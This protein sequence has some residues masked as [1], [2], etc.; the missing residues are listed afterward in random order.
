MGGAPHYADK[1]GIPAILAILFPHLVPT[2]G[3]PTLGFPAGRPGSRYNRMT[4]GVVHALAGKIGGGF[5]KNWRSTHG[6]PRPPR[7]TGL[8]KRC[9]GKPIPVLHGFSPEVVPEPEDW[10]PCVHTTGSWFLDRPDDW[11]PPPELVRFLATGDPPVYFGFGSMAGR[12]P[13][14]VTRIV[15]S[16][17]QQTG[18]RGL[19]ATGWGGLARQDLPPTVQLLDQAPHDWLFPCVAAV[20]HHGGAGTTAAGLRAGR[21][22]IICPFFGDQPF[23]GRRLHELGVGSRPIPQKKLS[24]E[25]LAAALRE[26]ADS[27]EIKQ[28]AAE[29]GERIRAEDGV[30]SAIN[31]IAEEMS[32]WQPR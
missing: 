26:V 25:K 18:L 2:A 9:D 32:R 23:W 17:L 8:L 22:T 31:A 29:L 4:Y 16:A 27:G 5:I 30:Q 20:V 13:E 24:V 10:P 28:R 6:L 11:R 3:F 19:L 14:R 21:P 7:R 15:I 1:L 12:D